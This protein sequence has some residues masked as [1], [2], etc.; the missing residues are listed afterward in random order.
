VFLKAFASTLKIHLFPRNPGSKKMPIFPF[1]CLL[2]QISFLACS[3]LNQDDTVLLVSFEKLKKDQHFQSRKFTKLAQ[4]FYQKNLL[5]SVRLAYR[6]GWNFRN[7]FFNS[8]ECKNYIDKSDVCCLGTIKRILYLIRKNLTRYLASEDEKTTRFE[9]IALLIKIVKEA[10]IDLDEE[11]K[12]NLSALEFVHQNISFEYTPKFTIDYTSLSFTIRDIQRLLP[13]E[14]I[15]NPSKNFYN[16]CSLLA[17]QVS[18]ISVNRCQ[19]IFEN[20]SIYR[21]RPI[22]V[23]LIFD[24]HCF[25]IDNELWIDVLYYQNGC[26]SKIIKFLSGNVPEKMTVLLKD[27]AR[28]CNSLSIYLFDQKNK[29]LLNQ[30]FR[31]PI[32]YIKTFLDINSMNKTDFWMLKGLIELREYLDRL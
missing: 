24:Y 16:L 27:S 11:S 7:A 10:P 2:L 30:V 21:A 14:D 15:K 1:I 28:F 20:D 22:I 31:F 29:E 8:V 4:K 5:E 3:N 26:V 12:R 19:K 13:V 9:A 6:K 17:F 25:Y 32:E 23:T 18:I